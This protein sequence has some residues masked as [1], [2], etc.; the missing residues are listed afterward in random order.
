MKVVGVVCMKVV[1]GV[2]VYKGV[3]GGMYE[4]GGSG[5]YVNSH[6]AIKK[7]RF[8][9]KYLHRLSAVSSKVWNGLAPHVDCICFHNQLSD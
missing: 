7:C 2:Y 1:R 8:V 5:L 9:V 4:G 3:G 6:T